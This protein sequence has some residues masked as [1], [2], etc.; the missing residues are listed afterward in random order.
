MVSSVLNPRKKVYS[1]FL[2]RWVSNTYLLFAFLRGKITP[3]FVGVCP[4][5]CCYGGCRYN[6]CKGY[7]HKGVHVCFVHNHRR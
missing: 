6:C 7:H 4:E 2:S 5:H 3:N 1:V